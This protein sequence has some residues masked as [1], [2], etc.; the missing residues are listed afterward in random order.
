[1]V[2][3]D[4]L[5]DR[6]QT[7]IDVKANNTGEY[8]GSLQA[9]QTEGADAIFM[10]NEGVVNECYPEVADNVAKYKDMVFC[11]FDAGTNQIEWIKGKV[12]G[13]AKLVGSV[14]QD[15]YQIGYQAVEQ[16]V[17]AVEKKNVTKE[18]GIPGTWYDST[19]IDEMIA[20]NIVYEG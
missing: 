1:M 7:K 6:F 17:F 4:N 12:A 18:V 20:K 5:S 15:S 9:A 11:G 14:A 10:C 13:A 19:N 3:K 16:A 8:K 2:E